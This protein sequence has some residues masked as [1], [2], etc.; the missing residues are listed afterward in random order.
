LPAIRAIRP[1][2]A[3]I[4]PR[5]FITWNG[6]RTIEGVVVLPTDSRDEDH[7]SQQDA[8]QLDVVL[9]FASRRSKVPRSVSIS[10]ASS[11]AATRLNV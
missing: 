6:A 9:A 2:A 4:S 8:Q 10:P 7:Q 3:A 1:L 11:H 5:W